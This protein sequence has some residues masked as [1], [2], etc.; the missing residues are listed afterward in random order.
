MDAR[1]HGAG[2]APGTEE[3]EMILCII[4]CPWFITNIA[5]FTRIFTA[6][7]T[8]LQGENMLKYDSF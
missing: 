1:L 3:D 7:L 2:T 8:D 5:F 4:P 6:L